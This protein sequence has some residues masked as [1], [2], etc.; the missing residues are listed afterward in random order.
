MSPAILQLMEKPATWFDMQ[1]KLTGFYMRLKIQKFLNFLGTLVQNRLNLK[2][3]QSNSPYV[4]Y[5]FCCFDNFFYKT[6]MFQEV[7]TQA[8]MAIR[9]AFSD[10][11]LNNERGLQFVIFWETIAQI[12][13][14][15][16]D[17]VSVPYLTVEF[18]GEFLGCM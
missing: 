14:A 4:L 16:K 11:Y 2:K 13:G 9:F 7:L 15:K 17:M 5:I 10:I 6:N 1:N 18:T 12:F 8:A 3:R